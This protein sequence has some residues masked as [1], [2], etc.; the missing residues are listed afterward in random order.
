MSLDLSVYKN[1]F[2]EFNLLALN[3]IEK[4]VQE[5]QHFFA[6]YKLI[7]QEL[8]KQKQPIPV[9]DTIKAKNFFYDFAK[10]YKKWQSMGYNFNIFELAGIKRDEVKISSILAWL[11]NP[12]GSHGQGSLFLN[13]FL[14]LIPEEA[15]SDNKKPLDF[16][17]CHV[18]TECYG[19]VESRMDIVI[20]TDSFFLIIESK[21]DTEEHHNQLNRYKEIA[22]IRAGKTKKWTLIYLTV[23]G[24]ASRQCSEAFSLTWNEIGEALNYEL[25]RQTNLPDNAPTR[26]VCEHFCQFLCDL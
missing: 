9:Y 1:F 8:L 20:D 17:N 16:T 4:Q 2:D 15:W 12:M 22:T 19:D 21:I 3:S 7:N 18:L 14:K 25:S 6:D 26:L 10:R 11:L 5:W 23:H 13:T 24:K